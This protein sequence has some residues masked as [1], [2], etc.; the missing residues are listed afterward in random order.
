MCYYQQ[1]YSLKKLEEEENKK[2]RFL[3]QSN[4][5]KHNFRSMDS[6]ANSKLTSVSKY[7]TKSKINESKLIDNP[8]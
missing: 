8:Y 6:R 5:R 7:D 1:Y 2:R 4:S 3:E